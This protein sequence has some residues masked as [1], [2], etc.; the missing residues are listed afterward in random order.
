VEPHV[1][2]VRHAGHSAHAG[3][4]VKRA[5]LEMISRDVAAKRQY[6]ILIVALDTVQLDIFRA[7]KPA[8][9]LGQHV[10]G[11]L[12]RSLHCFQWPES[13]R[14]CLDHG[15]SYGSEVLARK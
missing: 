9:R 13:L 7:A 8:S 6:A 5:L 4:G 11:G 2:F 12:T 15:D 14:P 1:D 10:G 3:H